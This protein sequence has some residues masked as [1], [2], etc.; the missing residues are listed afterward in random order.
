MKMTRRDRSANHNQRAANT[1]IDGVFFEVLTS[2]DSM[3]SHHK[4][5]DE[6]DLRNNSQINLGT[7]GS[8]QRLKQKLSLIN[9]KNLREGEDSK[10]LL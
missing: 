3:E 9:H 2:H 6:T 1:T 10:L 8:T 7:L 5:D 4:N